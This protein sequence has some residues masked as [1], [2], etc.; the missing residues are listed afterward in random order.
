MVKFKLDNRFMFFMSLVVGNWKM[1]FGIGESVRLVQEI[2]DKLN[3][4]NEV[5]V[6]P[7][8]VSL[9]AVADVVKG[10][11]E[12]GAQNIYQEESGA[13]TGEVSASMV[14]EVGCKYVIIGH[15]ERR[16]YFDE[17]EFL[18]MKLQLA[19]KHSL[20]P[21]FCVGEG[22]EERSVGKQNDIVEGQLIKGL[23]GLKFTHEE[24]VI[25]YEPVWAIGT[26]KTASA[27]EAEEMHAF[28]RKVLKDNG[29]DS[30]VKLLYGGSVK[31]GNSIELMS[32]KNIDGSLVGGA[33]L[34][35]KD[36]LSIIN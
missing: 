1:N 28:I 14:K 30:K 26:G 17:D 13:F 10:S 6:C 16:K 29:F 25:A 32:Q 31:P 22:L 4:K 21:I 7:P 11:I 36:F 27:N 19:M 23:E 24:L 3:S 18:N 12:L 20:V 2:V 5:A 34:N 15:S 33:A 9:S 8:F 35:A